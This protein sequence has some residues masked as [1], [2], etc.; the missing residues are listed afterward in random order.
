MNDRVGAD[1]IPT[2]MRVEARSYL[3]LELFCLVIFLALFGAENRVE[4][5][6]VGDVR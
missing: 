2:G 6:H 4:K 3:F 5:T 1:Q